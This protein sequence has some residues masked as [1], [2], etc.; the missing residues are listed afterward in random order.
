MTYTAGDFWIRFNIR[1]I[2]VNPCYSVVKCFVPVSPLK[3]SPDKIKFF[4]TKIKQKAYP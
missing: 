2:R 4:S 3:H 1:I